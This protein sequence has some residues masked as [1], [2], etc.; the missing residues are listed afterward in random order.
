MKSYLVLPAV[1][2]L[3]ASLSGQ[4]PSLDDLPALRDFE[5]HRITSADP[6]GGNADWWDIAPGQTRVLAE[7]Q[8]PG[9]IVHFRDNITSAEPHHLQLHVLRIYWD[10]EKEPSVEAPIGD[11]FGV[12]FGSVRGMR[13]RSAGARE[14]RRPSR[15]RCSSAERPELVA[16]W[17]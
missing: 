6:T 17:G 9:R 7:I 11:F 16:C 8:G 13:V 5:S 1:L 4:E 2:V 12:G 15:V 3:S 10:G 14:S